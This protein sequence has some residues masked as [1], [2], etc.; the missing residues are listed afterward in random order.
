MLAMAG[1][2]ERTA[3]RL[4]ELLTSSGF[5]DVAAIPTEGRPWIVEAT[6]V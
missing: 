3:Q 1:G 4:G 6:A 5:G 2:R